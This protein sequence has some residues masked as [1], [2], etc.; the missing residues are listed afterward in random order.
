MHR[1]P[2][3][4]II[5]Y[6]PQFVQLPVLQGLHDLLESIN[7]SRQ[8]GPAKV[9]NQFG[10][11][12]QID[13]IALVQETNE[14]LFD[15]RVF[16]DQLLVKCLALFEGELERFKNSSSYPLHELGHVLPT[17]HRCL[18][19]L[20]QRCFLKIDVGIGLSNGS[21]ACMVIEYLI[22]HEYFFFL[23]SL[24]YDEVVVLEQFMQHF[25][26]GLEVSEED[27]PIII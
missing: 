1:G 26:A 20:D 23:E 27:A 6:F 18:V 5:I 21:N 13:V 2:S 4:S 10:D 3:C 9:Y 19:L 7:F 25:L 16:F 22:V 8:I 14:C 24:A 17:Y 15:S 12:F 11:G